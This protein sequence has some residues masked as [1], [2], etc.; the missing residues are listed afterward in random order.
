MFRSSIINSKSKRTKE[1]RLKDE[2]HEIHILLIIKI[3][4]N[5]W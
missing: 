4:N 3:Y 1:M 5:F 2:N